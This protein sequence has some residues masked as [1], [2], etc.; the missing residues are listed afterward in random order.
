MKTGIIYHKDY[1]KHETGNHP[2]R[3]ERL[4]AIINLLKQSKPS[5]IE[6]ITPVS[7]IFE[8]IAYIHS[9]E[10]IRRVEYYCSI[11]RDLDVDTV[12]CK[13]SYRV[14]LLAVGGALTAIDGVINKK[15]NNAFALVRPPGHH[16]TPNRGMGFCL[17]NNVAIAARYCQKKY[18]LK[19]VLII[20]WDVHHGNGTNDAFYSDPSVLYFSTHQSPHY[21]GTGSIDEV[22]IGEGEGY[23]VNVPLPSGSGDSEYLYAL[24]EI[25]IPIAMEFNPDLVLISSG[26][27]AHIDDPLSGM[28]VTTEG[29]GNF[30]N[31]AR[32]IADNTCNGKMVAILE[33][34]YDLDALSQSVLSIL[35]SFGMQGSIPSGD[36]PATAVKKIVNAIKEVQKEYWKLLNQK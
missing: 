36:A 21:P 15:I 3:K 13:D 33:G 29:F 17:F 10:Y 34:G 18:N 2:E 23:T 11:E 9:P 16:A 30:A 35:D 25:L 8:Q 12:V 4:I 5:R 14:A 32:Y 19:K 28:G 22:G 27:D 20:D 1:L 31:I 24:K 6:C 7:A 26:Q